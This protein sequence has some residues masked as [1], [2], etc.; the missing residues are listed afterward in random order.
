[1]EAY[2]KVKMM[3]LINSLRKKFCKN[4][5]NFDIVE[6][7][8]SNKR[9]VETVLEAKQKRYDEDEQILIAELPIVRNQLL[10]DIAERGYSM[11]HP[12]IILS[13]PID[14]KNHPAILEE[15]LWWKGQGMYLRIMPSSTVSCLS[16]V[17]E[18]DE[19][20]ML[21]RIDEEE[22]EGDSFL[23]G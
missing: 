18:E 7:S 8:D 6:H 11:F 2:S 16:F 10:S 15:K 9:V 23:Y 13:K 22:R 1:M 4:K 14:F 17:V 12:Y 3:N 5:S 19:D 21:N 20:G